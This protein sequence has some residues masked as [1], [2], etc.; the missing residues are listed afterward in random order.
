MH[1]DDFPSASDRRRGE[2]VFAAQLLRAFRKGYK[3]AWTEES[4]FVIENPCRRS[5]I[6]ISSASFVGNPG[7]AAEVIRRGINADDAASG[8]TPHV[9][10]YVPPS[11]PYRGTYAWQLE[12][13]EKS[14]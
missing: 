10:V 4:G 13:T 1:E 8:Q 3:V 7:Q 9:Q 12:I 14:G 6:T 11:Y 2:Q 5:T